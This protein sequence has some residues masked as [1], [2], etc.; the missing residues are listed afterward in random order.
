MT[1]ALIVLRDGN[2]I[3][4]PKDYREP[5]EYKETVRFY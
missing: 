5:E 4:H 3:S 2:R 1:Q